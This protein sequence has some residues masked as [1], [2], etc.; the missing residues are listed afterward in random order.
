MSTKKHR[1]PPQS[2][3]QL[4]ARIGVSLYG[5]RFITALA[6]D[7]KVTDKTM[8]RWLN[9]EYVIPVTQWPKLVA[10]CDARRIELGRLA[11]AA[12]GRETIDRKRSEA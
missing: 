11:L 8:H 1:T 3:P 9:G 12:K 5:P 6:R 7:L 10:L 4:L 2:R